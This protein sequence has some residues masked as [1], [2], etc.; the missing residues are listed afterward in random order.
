[1]VRFLGLLAAS[2]GSRCGSPLAWRSSTLAGFGVS[3]P[4]GTHAERKP[5]DR[6]RQI[7]VFMLNTGLGNGEFCALDIDDL[8]I[9]DEIQLARVFGK[10]LKHRW[11]PLNRAALAAVRLHLRSR[12]NSMSGPLMRAGQTQSGYCLRGRPDSYCRKC[13]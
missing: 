9:A 7:A 11:V 13:S 3:T 6:K 10:G 8:C 1:M 5:G 2:S 12:G 4:L